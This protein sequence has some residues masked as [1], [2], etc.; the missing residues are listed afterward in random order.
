MRLMTDVGYIAM[1]AIYHYF[2]KD[3]QG[4]VRVV[5]DEGVL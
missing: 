5:A 3:H 4:N 1:S 2:I